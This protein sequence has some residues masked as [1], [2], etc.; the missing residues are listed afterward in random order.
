MLK[1][2]ERM[3]ELMDKFVAKLATFG[4]KIINLELPSL[5]YLF[6]LALTVCLSKNYPEPDIESLEW[7]RECLM[8]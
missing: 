6:F 3:E 5:P 1:K 7:I 2:G 4:E 8:A